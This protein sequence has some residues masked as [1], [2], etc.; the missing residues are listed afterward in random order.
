MIVFSSSSRSPSSSATFAIALTSS[1][2][3]ALSTSFGVMSLVRSSMSS[4]SGYITKISTRIARVAKPIRDFQ[5]VVPRV[6]G[7]I[8]ENTRIRMVIRALTSPNHS[9]PKMIVACRPTPAAPM[10]FAIVLSDRIAAIGREESCLYSLN[11][12]AGL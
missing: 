1:R 6:L 8:S 12:V 10:V 7:M 5:R 4:T 2:D 3:T 9:D 11:R